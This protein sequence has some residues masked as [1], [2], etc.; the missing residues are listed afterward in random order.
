MGVLNMNKKSC[1]FAFLTLAML[2]IGTHS[3]KVYAADT[4]SPIDVLGKAKQQIVIKNL[5]NV[6]DNLTLPSKV[7]IEGKEIYITWKSDKENVIS[8]S[9]GYVKRQSTNE[10]VTLT[11][12][13]KYDS[14][15][16]TDTVKAMVPANSSKENL[17]QSKVLDAYNLQLTFDNV[18]SPDREDYTVKLYGLTSDKNVPV[19]AVKV[20]NCTAILSVDLSRLSGELIVNDLPV[21]DLINFSSMPSG[22]SDIKLSLV[23]NTNLKL[24]KVADIT[25]NAHNNASYEEEVPIC[26]GLFNADTNSI[27]KYTYALKLVGSGSDWNFNSKMKIPDSGNYYLKYFIADNIDSMQQ[28]NSSNAI[29]IEK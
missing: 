10:L 20:D 1:N 7:S 27:V 6:K 18:P 28:V 21:S 14:Y 5:N 24:G 16:D 2:L 23:N 19:K 9:S 4:N 12:T 3:S 22:S 15:E 26:I 11:A 13:L 25:I 8:G 17:L 29:A